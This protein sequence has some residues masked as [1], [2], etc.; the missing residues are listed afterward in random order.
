MMGARYTIAFAVIAACLCG[1]GTIARADESRAESIARASAFHNVCEQLMTTR[2]RDGRRV[3]DELIGDA[4][5]DV[6]LRSAAYRSCEFSTPR[7]TEAGKS[8]VTATI[9]LGRMRAE[10]AERSGYD[11]VACA[12]E[13]LGDGSLASVGIAPIATNGFPESASIPPGWENTT[14]E[15][16]QLAE[17]AARQS[18]IEAVGDR[19]AELIGRDAAEGIGLRYVGAVTFESPRYDPCQVCTV[20]AR[21]CVKDALRVAYVDL[22]GP[23]ELGEKVIE[24][25]GHGTSPLSRMLNPPRRQVFAE[26]P[27]WAERR[28][29]ATGHGADADELIAMRAARIDATVKLAREIDKL[30][31][32]AGVGTTV[33][34]FILQHSDCDDVWSAYLTSARAT[35]ME[36]T[37]GQCRVT[38]EADLAWLWRIIAECDE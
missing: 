19:L 1:G 12:V 27:D 32:P 6:A 7:M 9:D 20:V 37:E 22:V 29:I 15:G 21:V 31:L 28:L 38:V 18:A 17:R 16:V 11:R 24:A 34:D 36:C 5:G 23:A 3:R 14:A 10:L 25:E 35:S 13:P 26:A 4:A 33:R 8:R 30:A 2:G